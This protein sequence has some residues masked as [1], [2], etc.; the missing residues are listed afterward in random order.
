MPLRRRPTPGLIGRP[1]P[2]AVRYRR[3]VDGS[4]GL[5]AGSARA[6]EVAGALCLATDLG[7]GL[8]LEHGLQSTLFAVRL[9]R[10]AGAG[11][12]VVR[13]AYYLSLVFHAG[14]MTD[15]HVPAQIFGGNLSAH[16]TPVVFGSPL[17][18]FGGV[19]RALPDAAAA[20]PA[21]A[22]QVAARLPRAMRAFKPQMNAMCEVAAVLARRI[23]MPEAFVGT[24]AYLTD[25]WDGKGPLGRAAREEIPLPL[26]IAQVARDAAIQRMLGG[27]DRAARIARERAGAA[28]DPEL[29]RLLADGAGEL[30]MLDDGSAWDE[31]LASEPDPPM[32]LDGPAIDRALA[33]MGDFADLASPCFSGHSSG[34]AALAAEA[35]RHCGLD[36]ATVA[37]VRRA[38]L[39]HDLGRVSVH[40]RIW[41]RPGPLTPDETEQVRLHAYHSE[42]VLLRAP[43]LAP[44][45]PLAGAHHE[46]LDGSGYHRGVGAAAQT[47]PARLLAAADAYQAMTEPRPYRSRLGA[48]RIGE[49]IAAECRAGRL[50]SVAA[51]AVL[52]AVGRPA[53]HVEHPAGLTEREVEV[54]RLLARGLQTKQVA[55]TLGVSTKTA[56]HHVQNAYAKIGVST[57]AGATL[58]AMEH[59]LLAWGEL[60]MAPAPAR[61]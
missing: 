36:A 32:L 27:P 55:R 26:R 47:A 18:G 48:E 14:C 11:E 10:G 17:E 29:A 42:R 30:L 24:L 37:S 45:A 21:R 35:A 49:E 51:A 13:E 19:L 60:P 2:R 3:V 16:H 50:D 53:P 38:G 23:G 7:V 25:R 46:R 40:P 33:A 34:V 4:A 57:R 12:H 20:P 56:D 9:A 44:L 15:A 59:G 28:F 22:L 5:D 39:L 52:A 58:F 8:P 1:R 6:A 31:V 61:A 43:V 54:V 41:A